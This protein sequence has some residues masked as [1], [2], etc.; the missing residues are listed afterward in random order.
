MVYFLH[1]PLSAESQREVRGMMEQ[2]TFQTHFHFPP[3]W[4]TAPL[5]ATSQ[6]AKYFTDNHEHLGSPSFLPGCVI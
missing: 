1:A 2:C 4:M 6:P 3:I 5:H